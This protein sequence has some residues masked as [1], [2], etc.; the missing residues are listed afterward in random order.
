MT[1]PAF[2]QPIGAVALA[3]R[4]AQDPV[5]QLQISRESSGLGGGSLADSDNAAARVR[6]FVMMTAQLHRLLPA[7][8][9]AK[10]AQKDEHQRLRR[11]FPFGAEMHL[12]TRRGEEHHVGSWGSGGE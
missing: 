12:A 5:W 7:E 10:M 9:S 2:C 3:I 6:E 11:G 4:I 8:H 1:R